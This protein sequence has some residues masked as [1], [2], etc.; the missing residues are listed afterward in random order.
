MTLIITQLELNRLSILSLIILIIYLYLNYFTKIREGIVRICDLFIP[1]A[2]RIV[3]ILTR[4]LG[5]FFRGV[6]KSI[7]LEWVMFFL[8]LDIQVSQ[9]NHPW[10]FIEW[11]ILHTDF[12]HAIIKTS[13]TN[14]KV[15]LYITCNHHSFFWK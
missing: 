1:Y 13:F 7:T 10:W 11:E 6:N 3:L 9:L 5:S 15:H 2:R 8:Y 4:S 14:V 12:P